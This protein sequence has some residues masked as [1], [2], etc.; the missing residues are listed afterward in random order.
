MREFEVFLTR[1]VIS[2]FLHC[3]LKKSVML[4]GFLYEWGEA[5]PQSLSFELKWMM[6]FYWYLTLWKWIVLWLS[7]HSV[8]N[9]WSREVQCLNCSIDE[10]ASD[11]TLKDMKKEK[12][13]H[14]SKKLRH[15]QRKNPMEIRNV[16]RKI[17]IRESKAKRRI[18]SIT[19]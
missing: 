10:R 19:P 13:F 3:K 1:R 18:S 4:N 7:F 14:P 12:S 15:R 8:V 2:A 5:F 16:K 17:S 9:I 6:C 11:C